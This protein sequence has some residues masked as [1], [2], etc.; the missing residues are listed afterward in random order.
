MAEL[1]EGK[2]AGEFIASEANGSR[3]REVVTIAEGEVL[4]AGT[5]LGQ[6]TIGSKYVALNQDAD[7]GEE[8]AAAILYDNVDATD[9]DVEAVVMIRDC[10]VNG[11]DLTW[12]ADIEAG[13]KTTA[14]AELAALGIIVR[15]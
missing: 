6:V 14:E 9:G 2:Y 4:E 1:V 13:E 7:T 11:N 10:E 12:P 5:V 15:Y 3:S 8:A